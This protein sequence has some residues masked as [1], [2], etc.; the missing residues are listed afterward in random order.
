MRREAGA[1]VSA[2][3][4]WEEVIR[5]EVGPATFNLRNMPARIEKA[6]D[7]WADLRKKKRSLA[8]A[9]ASFAVLIRSAVTDPYDRSRFR[10]PAVTRL[11]SQPLR[12]TVRDL[13]RTT[14]SHMFTEQ[15][16]PGAVVIVLALAIAPAALRWW[17]GRAARGLADD[18]LIAERLH[19]HHIRGSVSPIAACLVA[20]CLGWPWWAF[21]SRSAAVPCASIAASYPLTRRSVR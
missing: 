15:S 11:A 13:P 3:C 2:P 4:T 19:A 5:G 12:P 20:L 17:W 6:G 10:H 14:P 8:R 7:V 1:P 16:G 9:I 18:P 21:W